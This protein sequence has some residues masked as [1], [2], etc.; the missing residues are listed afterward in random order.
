MRRA[1]LAATF[2]LSL[3]SPRSG[4]AFVTPRWRPQPALKTRILGAWTGE[5]VADAMGNGGVHVPLTAKIDEATMTFFIEVGEKP[6]AFDYTIVSTA[7]NVL[8]L[9]SPA[10][11]RDDKVRFSVTLEDATHL[12]IIFRP[13]SSNAWR[14]ELSRAQ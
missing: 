8:E 12:L 7:D 3:T 10:G 13:D 6:A 5:I 2:A 1:L 9:E 11:Y 14:I 4:E